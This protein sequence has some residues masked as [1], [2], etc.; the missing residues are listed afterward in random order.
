M[1][2]DPEHEALLQEVRDLLVRA[3]K[4]DVARARSVEKAIRKAVPKGKRPA[5]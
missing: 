4:R 1:K 3:E 5:P 2:L